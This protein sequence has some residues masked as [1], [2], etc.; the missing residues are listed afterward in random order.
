MGSSEV[1]RVRTGKMV[2][3]LGLGGLWVA[4][5]V[6]ESLIFITAR[7]MSAHLW[8]AWD[9]PEGELNL[10]WLLCTLVTARY[11]PF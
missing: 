8:I 9:A 10:R 6:G 3:A 5:V 1:G 2:E 11:L 7:S 4:L